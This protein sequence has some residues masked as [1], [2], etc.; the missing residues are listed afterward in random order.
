MDFNKMLNGLV[1]SNFF[2]GSHWNPEHL[3]GEELAE[4]S[5]AS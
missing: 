1:I 3:E 2:S 5:V 4:I